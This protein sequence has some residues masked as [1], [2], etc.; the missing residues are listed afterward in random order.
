MP[1]EELAK[2][3]AHRGQRANVTPVL[4]TPNYLALRR[5]FFV[6]LVEC[7]WECSIDQVRIDWLADLRGR[8][9]TGLWSAARLKS[10]ARAVNRSLRRK[11]VDRSSHSSDSRPAGT[12][13]VTAT[14]GR[15]TVDVGGIVLGVADER[16]VLPHWSD[17]ITLSG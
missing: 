16:I 6:N 4:V 15:P 17:P 14:L 5:P 13:E 9:G 3:I 7:L 1:L 10:Q 2:Q 12:I 8:L 11:C